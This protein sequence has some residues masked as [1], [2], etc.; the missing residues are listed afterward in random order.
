[1][2]DICTDFDAGLAGLHG[3]A[4]HVHLLVNYP[5][6]VA[7]PPGELAQGRVVPPDTARI[8][9]PAPPLLAGEPALVRVL[10]PRSGG[11]PPT[12]TPRQ[13]IK[14]QNQPA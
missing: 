1:M 9:G 5:P 10:L 3:Q 7:L 2:R 4:N 12:S 11:A 6:K 8:P 14:Q 13:Y